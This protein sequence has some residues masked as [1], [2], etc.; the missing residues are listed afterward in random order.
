LSHASL[1]NALKCGTEHATM[2]D[3]DPCQN[4]A[5]SKRVSQSS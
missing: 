4:G 1:Y 2:G 5:G 3:T